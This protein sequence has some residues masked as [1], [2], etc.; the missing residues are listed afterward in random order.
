MSKS[1]TQSEDGSRATSPS[2][3]ARV[4]AFQVSLLFE[5]SRV[6]IATG[7]AFSL[8]VS[9]FSWR[10]ISH[11]V[12]LTWLGL[13]LASAAA[14]GVVQLAYAQRDPSA[15]VTPLERAYLVALAFD[16]AVWGLVGTWL[17]REEDAISVSTA[18][19]ALVGVSAIGSHV[20]SAHGLAYACFTLP[21]LVPTA[22]YHFVQSGDINAVGAIAVLGYLAQ[23]A[24]DVRRSVQTTRELARLRYEL[25]VV[26][27]ARAKAL[28]EAERSGRARADALAIAEAS[29]AAKSRFLATMSHEM[30]TP[31][32]GVL[33]ALQILERRVTSPEDGALVDLAASSGQHLLGLI[34]DVLDFA[35]LDNASMRFE[36]APFDLRAV[37]DDV[38][39]LV[40]GERRP[41]DVT[42]RVEPSA[43]THAWTTGDASR[44]RQIVTHLVRNGAK[45]SA[46]GVVE[47]SLR[48]E[49]GRLVVAVRD[50]GIGIE[51]DELPRIFEPFHQADESLGRRFEGAGLGLALARELARAMGGDVIC[52]RS[53]PGAGS[54]FELSL[55]DR[56][57]PPSFSAPRTTLPPRRAGE[58]P[59]VLLVDDNELN[60]LLGKRILEEL[61]AE[62]IIRTGGE[63]GARAAIE[64]R[65]DLVFMDIQMPDVDGVEATRRIREH[66]A[67]AGLSRAP[68]VALT[69]HAQSGD[70]ARFLAAGMDEYI[71]KP[72]RLA[73]IAAALARF[74]EPRAQE[75]PE[76]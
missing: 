15:D 39:R 29:N 51:P 13:K 42:I 24:A 8:L 22:A 70:R 54:T 41:G 1:M 68:I 11:T 52:A 67:R 12:V 74:T 47:T 62:P 30:R 7:V 35:E 73:D 75:E 65:P 59:R 50:D 72:Y 28:D 57:P 66:E 44:C 27:E 40:G 58:R 56:A 45:F 9:W 32:N 23:S 64:L 3:E 61:G 37:L 14:R 26:A 19:A 49:E 10:H 21:I 71:P 63:D 20:F 48:R 17:V 16:G 69:A 31:L 25:D 60:A 36:D 34:D 18:L 43:L 4:R 46:N 5:R 2:V 33:G 55:P 76:T 6:P 38:V 53:T